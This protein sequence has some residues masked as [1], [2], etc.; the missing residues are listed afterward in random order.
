MQTSVNLVSWLFFAACLTHM[1]VSPFVNRQQ[2]ERRCSACR[3]KL[4]HV[5]F[6]MKSLA[7]GAGCLLGAVSQRDNARERAVEKKFLC[8]R[9]RAEG[10]RRGGAA[11]CRCLLS[12]A[13]S[14]HPSLDVP[15]SL[16]S[17]LL[18]YF[19]PSSSGVPPSLRSP[20]FF[21]F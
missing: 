16:Q 10:W 7:F 3:S 12:P 11:T 18:T 4:N 15:P 9:R 5:L 20:P 19:H 13:P 6:I 1:R 2:S 17:L 14:L 8:A 21:V